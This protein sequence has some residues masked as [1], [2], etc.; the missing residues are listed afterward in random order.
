MKKKLEVL[1]ENEDCLVLN[2]P[3]GLLSIPDRFDETIPNVKQMLED[4][5]TSALIVHRLDRETSGILL[6]A[7]NEEAHKD[8]SQQFEQRSIQKEYVAIVKGQVAQTSGLIDEP[9]L[10]HPTT[11]GKMRVYKKGKAS[12]TNFE[13]VDQFQYHAFVKLLP[14][15]GRTHQLRVHLAHIGNSILCDPLYGNGKPFFLSSIKRDFKRNKNS[16]ERPLIS[17]TALHAR[18]LTFAIKGESICVSCEIP[19]D[20]RASLNQMRKIG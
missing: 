14:K 18:E 17:R 7:K 13:V 8:L 19:K 20:M 6:L 15:T 10:P 9:I 12:Q 1:F 5:G 11:R 2:K 4:Q 3:A 16:E